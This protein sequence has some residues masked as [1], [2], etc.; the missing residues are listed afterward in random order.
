[1]DNKGQVDTFI[2]DSEKG[3]DTPPYELLKSKLFSLEICVKTLKWADFSRASDNSELLKTEKSQI[4]LQFQC[5]T[6]YHSWSFAVLITVTFEHMRSFVKMK[7]SRIGKN[8]LS[9]TDA[10]K[11]WTSHDF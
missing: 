2:L 4:W 5:P 6:G 9:F 7:S 1:M 11:S 8:T 3:F 10:S